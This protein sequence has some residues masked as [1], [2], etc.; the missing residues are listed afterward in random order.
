MAKKILVAARDLVFRSKLRAVVTSSGGELVQDESGCDLAVIEIESSDWEAR[1]RNLIGR[2]I[3]V[4]AF[5]SHVRA[6]LLRSA[7]DAGARAVPNSQVEAALREL[8]QSLG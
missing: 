3:P 8:I 5:G 2:G 1:V 7:R 4:L 6:D